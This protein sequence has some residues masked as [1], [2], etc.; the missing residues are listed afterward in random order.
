VTGA[1]EIGVEREGD[2]SDEAYA[3]RAFGVDD[4]RTDPVPTRAPSS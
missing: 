3:R 4:V 1:P 2:E